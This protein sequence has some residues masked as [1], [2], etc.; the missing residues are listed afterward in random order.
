M[1]QKKEK[2][3]KRKNSVTSMSNKKCK[4]EIAVENVEEHHDGS[5]KRMYIHYVYAADN[6]TMICRQ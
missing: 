2:A 6:Y 4:L 3:V 5:E 1:Q